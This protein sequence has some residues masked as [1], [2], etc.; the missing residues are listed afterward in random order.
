MS[1]YLI[2]LGPRLLFG[3]GAYLRAALN[4]ERWAL[5]RVNTIIGNL[6]IMKQT[7]M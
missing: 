5:V 2:I 6:I 3:G 7:A 4:R 1:S